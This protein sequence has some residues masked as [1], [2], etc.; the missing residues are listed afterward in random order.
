MA[1]TIRLDP[2]A[3]QDLSRLDPPIQKKLLHYLEARVAVTS[4][5]PQVLANRLSGPPGDLWRFRVGDYRIVATLH[6]E[7]ITVLV[8]AAPHRKEI[9]QRLSRLLP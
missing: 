4:E 6:R 1:S 9:Y 8:L 5:D 7:T 3:E 2:R